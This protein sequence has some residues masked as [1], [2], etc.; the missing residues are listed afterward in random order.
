MPNRADEPKH[1]PASLPVNRIRPAY[2][3]VA[4][5]LRDLIVQGSLPPGTRLPIENDLAA[6][7]G[8]SRGTIREA[9]RVLSSQDLIYAVRGASGGTFVAQS[10]P[11]SLSEYLTTGIELLSADGAITL[12]ELLEARQLLE[13]PAARLAA[14][15]RNEQHLAELQSALDDELSSSPADR[16]QHHHR[17][18][19]V[20]LTASGNRLLELMTRPMYGVIRS[21]YV[22]PTDRRDAWEQIDDDHATIMERIAEGDDAGAARAMDDH[23]VRLNS[24]YRTME[25]ARVPA[26]PSPLAA[27]QGD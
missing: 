24:I 20:I 12:D 25:A 17:F 22:L 10:D 1:L 4:Q 7:F 2:E 9:L 19:L 23:L 5:Q 14:A 21:R 8:V 18:H 6:A 13:V 26:R 15:R 16:H 27:N 3:Q 11:A